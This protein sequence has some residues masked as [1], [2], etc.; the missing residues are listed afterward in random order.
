MYFISLGGWC[1]PHLAMKETKF[2][3][4]PALPFDYLKCSFEGV[5]DCLQNDFK[6]FFPRIIKRDYRYPQYKF[7]YGKYVTFFHHDLLDSE[8]IESF[9]RR[10]KRINDTINENTCVFIRQIMT[11]DYMDEVK[12]YQDFE[13]IINSKYP[14]TKY[15]ICYIISN[16]NNTGYYKNLS[17][18]SF[19]FTMKGFGFNF[20]Y[21]EYLI[22]YNYIKNNDLFTNIPDPIDI[23]LNSITNALFYLENTNIPFVNYEDKFDDL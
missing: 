14:N 7:F 10:F 1:I 3:E 23:E 2:Q 21:D 8:V 19:L 15:I 6:N 5:I 20:I 13:N 12:Y 16:Q 22:I 18:K 11:E 4:S 9:N 17:D